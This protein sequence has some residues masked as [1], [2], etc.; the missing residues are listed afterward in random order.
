MYAKKAPGKPG[1]VA[2]SDRRQTLFRLCEPPF[3]AV[4]KADRQ[5]GHLVQNAP[6]GETGLTNSDIKPDLTNLNKDYI[7]LRCL[8]KV[9]PVV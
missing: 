3:P 2:K 5:C 8:N 6:A 1:P 4:Q 7:K 9:Q